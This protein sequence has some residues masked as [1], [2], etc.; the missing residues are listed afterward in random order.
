MPFALHGFVAA[1]SIMGE[2]LTLLPPGP[3]WR[4]DRQASL[5]VR[6][7]GGSLASVAAEAAL[8]GANA[9]ALLDPEGVAEIL[10]AARVEL[11]GPRTFRLSQMIRGLGGSEPAAGRALNVGARLVVLDGAAEALTAALDDVG[12]SWRYRIGPANADV[13]GTAMRE[14]VASVGTAALR[15]LAPVHPQARRSGAG[16]TLSWIRRTRIDGDSWEA[17][18]VPLGEE[19]ERYRLTVYQAG[20][21]KRV[22]ESDRPDLLYPA[23]SEI[24]D[25]GEAQPSLDIALAQ[26][27]LAA[28]A[29]LPWR[30]LVTI[31]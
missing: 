18:E 11:I 15:P 24:E 21:V 31:R 13:A 22:V 12:R 19:T 25:F 7:R 6:L 28:G 4:T 23:A 9:L 14:L 17:F 20:E 10:T 2:T 27:S 5:D 3:L 16:V 29:G 1:P 8:A 26:L 30:G